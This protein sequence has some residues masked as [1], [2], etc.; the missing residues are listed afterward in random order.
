MTIQSICFTLL[1]ALP[2]HSDWANARP[3]FVEN[4][5]VKIA[6]LLGFGR[7]ITLILLVFTCWGGHVESSVRNQKNAWKP[8]GCLYDSFAV[9][10][11]EEKDLMWSFPGDGIQTDGRDR[12]VTSEDISNLIKMMTSSVDL[13][14]DVRYINSPGFVMK[15][16]AERRIARDGSIVI[17]LSFLQ[18][19]LP[20]RNGWDFFRATVAHEVGHFIVRKSLHPFK[21]SVSEGFHKQ[22]RVADSPLYKDVEIPLSENTKE[23]MVCDVWAGYVFAKYPL[24]SESTLRAIVI[25][26][27]DLGSTKKLEERAHGAPLTRGELF[28]L[29]LDFENL[30][31]KGYKSVSISGIDNYFELFVAVD[32]MVLSYCHP[33]DAR[34]TW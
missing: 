26:W 5:N 6:T 2:T 11:L 3:S 33:E 18:S 4:G 8:I 10:G 17:D 28:K 19:V 30:A 13:Q 32:D 31:R 25:R 15:A 1:L 14:V 21:I 29:G 34:C 23:E 12:K 7:I 16:F 24:P 27:K 20:L 9:E 22:V